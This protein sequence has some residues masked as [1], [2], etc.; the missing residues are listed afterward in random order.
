MPTVEL[1]FFEGCPS[2][3]RLLPVVRRLAREADAEVVLRRVET[4]EAA[5]A[6]RFLGSPS[7][8]VDGV[9]ID[10]GAAARDDYRLTSRLYR[11]ENGQ[12]PLPPEEWIRAALLGK[13]AA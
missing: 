13:R 4:P 10:R 5:E 7:V 3:E 12:A 8:R 11:D 9:D 1:L 6:Q 2:H